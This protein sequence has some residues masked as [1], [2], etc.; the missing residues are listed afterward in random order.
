MQSI[1]DALARGAEMEIAAEMAASAADDAAAI[2]EANEGL[3]DLG[4]IINNTQSVIQTAAAKNPAVAPLLRANITPK[5]AALTAAHSRL[6][7][8]LVSL[9]ART[10]ARQ[11]CA[12]PRNYKGGITAAEREGTTKTLT[13]VF[14]R[15]LLQAGA[16]S[17][18]FT[19]SGITNGFDVFHLGRGDSAV[20]YGYA[21]GTCTPH[22]TNTLDKGKL[23]QGHYF[24]CMGIGFRAARVDGAPIRRADIET[25]GNGLV[26]WGEEQG[27]KFVEYPRIGQMP[28]LHDVREFAN[29]PTG[30]FFDGEPYVQDEPLFVLRHKEEGHALRLEF[31]SV[32]TEIE[33]PTYLYCWLYGEHGQV[34]GGK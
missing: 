20:P 11:S 17:L 22:I 26:Y 2:L 19:R 23:R 8:P 24:R 34:P 14:A 6:M 33:S 31:E 4:E 29:V 13:P 21:S 32:A 7:K 1:K 12:A 9:G 28:A 3:N 16:L 25:I 27:K 18:S 15:L 30:A 5:V 10:A